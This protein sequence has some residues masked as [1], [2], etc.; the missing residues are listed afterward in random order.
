MKSMGV[1]DEEIH[2]FADA[3]HWLYYFP[4]LAIND[5]K[6]LGVKV[7][8]RRS[9]ITTDV[10]PYYDSFVR[11]QF[12][13]LKALDKIKFGKRYTIFSPLDNQP[14][15]DHDRQTGEGVAPQEYT[16][17][18]LQLVEPFPQPLKFLEEKKKVFFTAATLRPETMYGQTNCFVGPALDYGAFEITKDEVFICTERSALNLA[19]QGYAQTEGK[20][21]KL[22]ALKGEELVGC[23][24]KAP[25]AKYD[26]VY[27]L[28]MES[29]LATKVI[30]CF[31]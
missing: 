13:R 17:I 16:L 5:L 11:W 4:P 31:N 3:K 21:V 29:V 2:R 20:V 8:W 30:T 1:P 18:K 7:D 9:F 6:R 24:V 25:L 14:C 10:N 19:Y 22:A 15:M 12:R 27:V 23:R 28:P 26:H